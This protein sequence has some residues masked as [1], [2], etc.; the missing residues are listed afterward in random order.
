MKYEF[1]NG[2]SGEFTRKKLSRNIRDLQYMRHSL[3]SWP[4]HGVSF[5]NTRRDI[6]T[7]LTTRSLRKEFIMCSP[8]KIP[9]KN[10]S[11]YVLF[12][13]IACIGA[14][15]PHYGDYG[16]CNQLMFD[17]AFYS[18]VIIL[19]F[20]G[21]IGIWVIVEIIADASW[22]CSRRPEPEDRRLSAIST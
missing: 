3:V 15:L 21:I 19:A 11:H 14:V 7:I 12:L 4:G 18:T 2:M 5:L 16:T 9:A 20:L 22:S 10:A 6:G 1:A 17:T 8:K 13:Y